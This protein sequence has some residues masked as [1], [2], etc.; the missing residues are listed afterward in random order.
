MPH[1][2]CIGTWQHSRLGGV[3]EGNG[4]FTIDA[5]S[6]PSFTGTHAGRGNAP[7]LAGQC[8]GTVIQFAIVDPADGTLICYLRGT[9][10][11]A[12]D[13]SFIRGKH[14]K[15]LAMDAQEMDSSLVLPA[16]DDWEADKST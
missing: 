4:E 8:N 10:T 5:H 16:P 11:T 14:S 12:G 15:P 2:K 6:G 9:I 3:M 13:K 7:L 1:D